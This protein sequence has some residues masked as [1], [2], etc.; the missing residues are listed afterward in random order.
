MK[1]CKAIAAEEHYQ[2]LLSCYPWLWGTYEKFV[3]KHCQDPLGS[4]DFYEMRHQDR[5]VALCS[6]RTYPFVWKNKRLNA[7]CMMDLATHPDYRQKRLITTLTEEASKREFARGAD[8]GLGFASEKLFHAF[9]NSKIPIQI[10]H[11]Y[12][13]PPDSGQKF[14]FLEDSEAI[15]RALNANPCALQVKREEAT[16]AYLKACPLFSRVEFAE[17]SGI[18]FCIGI[19]DRQIQVLEISDYSQDAI[20]T[21]IRACQGFAKSVVADFPH[22]IGAENAVLE[23][24]I[25]ALTYGKPDNLFSKHEKIWMPWL[26]RK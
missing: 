26:E 4:H 6:A 25:Y 12:R 5:L 1:I 8:L 18:V 19:N 14:K 2:F 11:T 7:L 15:C 3:W 10:F 17:I 22:E 9:Y 21:V 16:L 13:F 24:K 20:L 23:K